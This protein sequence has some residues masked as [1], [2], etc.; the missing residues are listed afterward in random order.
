MA[1]PRS[2]AMLVPTAERLIE[3]ASAR[4]AES[5][6]D[7]AGLQEI[8]QDAGITRPS[9][10]HHFPT[11]A[12]LYEAVVARAFA[13]IG[14][15]LSDARGA[16]RGYAR[17]ALALFD[18]FSALLER[19]PWVARLLV[20][21]MLASDGPGRALI[22]ERGR[23]LLD[24]LESDLR[25]LAGPLVPRNYPLRSALLTIASNALLQAGAGSL[26]TPLWSASESRTLA[27]RLLLC[28]EAPR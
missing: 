28:E 20:R 14:R 7:R 4:F 15:S 1:R 25:V 23:A 27:R 22:A 2:D 5:G 26:A 3:A 13:A 10:L 11:K 18:A 17:A 24:A 8:A 21:E 19:E 16:H 9:L 6:F 12:A